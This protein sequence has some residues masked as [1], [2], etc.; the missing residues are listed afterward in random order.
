MSKS[1]KLL[2]ILAAGAALAWV[3][4]LLFPPAPRVP[5]ETEFVLLD[6]NKLTLASLRGRPVL[7]N[8]WSTTCPP[9]VE[10]LPDLIRIYQ[11]WQPRG[12]ELIAVA[13]PYDPPIRVQE[14]VQRHAVP[15]PVALDVQGRVTSAFGGV[16]F[17][18]ASFLIGPNGITE[19]NATGR[20]DT[21]KV[22]RILARSLKEPGS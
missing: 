8:F 12:F 3:A 15:Y 11:E 19:L 10:E 22:G 13:M 4:T 17:I 18:P 16:P 1:T 21:D 14:F 9:C 6:G 7:V 5:P 20:L 2:V